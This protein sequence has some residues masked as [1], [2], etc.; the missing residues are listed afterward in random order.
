MLPLLFTSAY[1]SLIDLMSA[2]TFLDAFENISG[3]SG[4]SDESTNIE[5]KINKGNP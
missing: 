1:R 3:R 4:E 2:S 5:M